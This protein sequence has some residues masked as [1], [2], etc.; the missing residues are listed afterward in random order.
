[1]AMPG[2]PIYG[3]PPER[4]AMLRSLCCT[5]TSLFRRRTREQVYSFE[6]FRLNAC[7]VNVSVVFDDLNPPVRVRFDWMGTSH[8]YLYAPEEISREVLRAELMEER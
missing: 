1:M 3:P 5:W 8:T 7:G 6:S 2:Y 4:G